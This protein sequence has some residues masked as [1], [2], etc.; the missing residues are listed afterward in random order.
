LAT[1]FTVST[2][3][4]AYVLLELVSTALETGVLRFKIEDRSIVKEEFF[5]TVWLSGMRDTSDSFK[6]KS[7]VQ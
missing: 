2:G 5:G 4:E 6:L 1:S 3:A 7:K